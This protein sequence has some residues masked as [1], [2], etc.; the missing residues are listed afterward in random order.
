MK[1]KSHKPGEV[2]KVGEKSPGI[3]DFCWISRDPASVSG[4]QKSTGLM[5]NFSL[6]GWPWLAD[7]DEWGS[8]SGLKPPFLAGSMAQ[9][10][11]EATQCKRC[12]RPEGLCR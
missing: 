11:H 3:V 9:E 7:Q 1:Q 4:V 5:S 6:A 2:I 8:D 12:E 10:N